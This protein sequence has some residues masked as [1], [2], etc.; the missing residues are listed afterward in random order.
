[1]S[2]AAE[3][4]VVDADRE[5]AL[6]A[7][8]RVYRKSEGAR[9]RAQTLRQWPA[10]HVLATTGVA[11]DHYEAGTFWPKL[12]TLVGI[13]Q[14]QATTS[15]WGQAFLAN[16]ATLALPTFEDSDDAGTRFVGRILMH[17]GMPT[18][19]LPDF[20]RLIS[21]RRHKVSGLGSSEFVAWAR[22]RAAQKQLYNIAKPVAR[23]LQYGDE[24]AVDVTDRCFDLLEAVSAGSDGSDVPLP[25]RFRQVAI[26]LHSEGSIQPVRRRVGGTGQPDAD[27]QPRLVVDAFGQGPILRLPA[28]GDAPD[29]S[30]AWLVGFDAVTQRVGTRALT[31]GLNEPAPQTD[32]PIPCPVRL[33]TAALSGREDLMV[34]LTVVDETDPLLAF[35]EDGTLLQ[36]GL[37]LPSRPT[38]L[39][40]PGDLTALDAEG[41]EVL[42]ESPLPPGWSGWC[43]LLVDLAQA[44]C[45]TVAGNVRTHPLRQYASA[46]VATD[47]PVRGVRTATALP[48][49]RSVPTIYLPHELGEARWEVALLQGGGEV[50]S[51][52]D[53]GSDNPDPNSVWDAVPRPVVG[54][55]MVRVR[56]PWGR[57]VTRTVNVVEGISVSFDPPWRRFSGQGL[58]PCLAKL[59]LATGIDSPRR[60][61]VFHERDL[62]QYLRVG[63]RGN[64]T[65]LVVTPPHMT[66]AY[67]SKSTMT[68]ASVKPLRLFREDVVEDPG[69]LILDIG[70]AASP[71][72]E[73]VVPAGGIQAIEPGAGRNGAYLFSL[74]KIVDT[75]NQYPQ[76]KLAL[77]VDGELTVGH[78]RPQTLFT[79]IEL[80]DGVLEFSECVSVDGLVALVY[81]TRAPWRMPVSLPVVDGRAEL[82]DVLRD[83]GPLRVMV[84]IEDPWVPEPVPGWPAARRSVLVEADGYLTDGDDDE[85]ALA[86]Y[87]AG[88]G[89]FPPDTADA[90]RLWTIRGLIGGLAL[91]DRVG[92]VVRCIDDAIMADPR[93]A[94]MALTASEVP[95][96]AIPSLIVRTGL[97][98]ASLANAHDD[99]APIWTGRGA[100]PAALISAADL[101]WSED[102]VMAAVNV[103]GEVTIELI[104]GTDPFA[105]EG[106]FDDA[107]DRFDTMPGVRDAFV[108][109]AGLVP[110]G[111]LSGDARVVAAM[112]FIKERHHED[113][114]FLIRNA[115]KLLDESDRM[116]RILADPRATAAF[117]ARRHATRT[118]GWR[119]VPA[120][121]LALALAARHAARGHERATSWLNTKQRPWGDL[122]KVV[123]QMVT[124]DLLLAEFLV[125]STSSVSQGTDA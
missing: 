51:K 104:A 46:R 22:A 31:P 56:G 74:S 63:A 117:E 91:S 82:P 45:V 92:Q 122:A 4:P 18:R 77:G 9:A 16:L 101:A 27:Q 19:C 47:D 52:W 12:T 59:D 54:T 70:E 60:V 112:G 53:S 10:V 110:K 98:W 1:V 78:I 102:E 32:V 105:S 83:S 108:R 76:V 30:A 67:Q 71:T 40:F 34:T 44:E 103:C 36:A 8:G 61:L 66:V 114:E 43:L 35:G 73:V 124:I 106:R 62:E 26:Q 72:L 58:L 94:L 7:L 57:G 5:Q 64:Y 93:P 100:L 38:W 15:E 81:T 24:F 119:A 123:P 39:L 13:R 90:T 87:L 11:T 89:D 84:R 68:P 121:S 80:V 23:F 37:A 107:A 116:L 41:A 55:F 120:I 3:C 88:E 109:Q 118:G 96:A 125:A 86:A 14:D 85:T 50:L 69:T 21:E 115:H 97:A 25:D 2:L 75:L 79:G 29:G 28:V 49:V 95:D 42:S 111:L 48:V 17:S 99:E 6:E 20:Y 65:T 33:A 113:L